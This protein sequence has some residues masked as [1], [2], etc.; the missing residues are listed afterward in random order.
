[1]QDPD[2][3]WDT[4]REPGMKDYMSLMGYDFYDAQNAVIDD[5]MSQYDDWDDDLDESC[6]KKKKSKKLAK[7]SLKKPAKDKILKDI[8]KLKNESLKEELEG[9]RVD[10]DEEIIQIT[11]KEDGGV[12]VET[13]PK[14]SEE[15][16]F[17]EPPMM[18]A[19]DEEEVIM[20]L[21]DEE[22]EEIAEENPES[23]D[24]EMPE[25]EEEE[26]EID[27][28]DTDSFD[29]LG[30]SYLKEAYENVKSFK[31][32]KVFKKDGKLVVEGILS[33]KSGKNK[34][35]S[36]IFESAHNKS[37]KKVLL[38]ENKQITPNSKS[39]RLRGVVK[40]KKMVCESLRYNYKEGK[41]RVSGVCRVK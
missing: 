40:N 21:T 41:N 35:T 8:N 23:E 34:K 17:E 6:G 20:P 1:M 14:D 5:Y 31:T 19:E 9:I 33:F 26:E 2:R 27:D 29:E 28:I 15:P 22:E 11:Q 32:S 25:E 18:G 12:A 3:P 16:M 38:G 4:G 37:K 30:E 24:E 36:F 39:F 7:E 10:T 13:S